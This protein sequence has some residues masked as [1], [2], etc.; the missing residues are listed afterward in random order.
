MKALTNYLSTVTACNETESILTSIKKYLGESTDFDVYDPDIL[1]NINAWFGA[2]WDLG[3]G[4]KEPFAVTG[5]DEVWDDFTT[6]AAI[7]SMVKMYIFLKSR[8]VF[9]P[10]TSSFVLEAL[11]QQASEVEW[12]LHNNAVVDLMKG[13]GGAWKMF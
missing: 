11:K 13:G 8:I 2:L 3:V 5:P 9:D 7:Q 4:P 10:P 12:R 1:M 6:H